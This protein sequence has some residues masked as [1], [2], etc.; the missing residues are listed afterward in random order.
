MWSGHTYLLDSHTAPCYV[1]LCIANATVRNVSRHSLRDE[2]KSNQS[3]VGINWE[4][5]VSIWYDQNDLSDIK[6][7]WRYSRWK[8]ANRTVRDDDRRLAK[9]SAHSYFTS[10]YCFLFRRG[11]TASYAA[12]VN[13]TRSNLIRSSYNRYYINYFPTF[14]SRQLWELR[15]RKKCVVSSDIGLWIEINIRLTCE[16]P[17][18]I[19]VFPFLMNRRIKSLREILFVLALSYYDYVKYWILSN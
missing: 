2:R 4:S 18:N 10:S 3:C 11:R 12:P 9:C 16:F 8:K 7:Q 13:S 14:L 15:Y 17:C 19:F 1:I 6:Q 5:E